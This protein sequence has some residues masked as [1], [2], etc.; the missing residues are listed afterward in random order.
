MLLCCGFEPGFLEKPGFSLEWPA[1]RQFARRV[2][3]RPSALELVHVNEID[4][5]IRVEDFSQSDW[6]KGDTP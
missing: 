3:A 5:S 6:L 2:N 4:L 1:T